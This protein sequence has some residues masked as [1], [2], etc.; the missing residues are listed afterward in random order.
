MRG[1]L[2]RGVGGQVKGGRGKT[3]VSALL[4][5]ELGHVEDAPVHHDPQVVPRVVPPDLVPP[6]EGV[7]A[8]LRG[9][10]GGRGGAETGRGGGSA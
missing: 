10:G 6:D 1:G 2:C 7:V 9:R 3:G 8:V 4:P 5:D